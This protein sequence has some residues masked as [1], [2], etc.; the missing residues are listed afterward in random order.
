MLGWFTGKKSN[1]ESDKILKKD[2][3]KEDTVDDD[4]V[5]HMYIELG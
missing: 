1:K 5:I 2:E 4:K 3:T